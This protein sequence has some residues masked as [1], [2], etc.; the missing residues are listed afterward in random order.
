MFANIHSFSSIRKRDIA[1]LGVLLAGLLVYAPANVQ[2]LCDV[3]PQVTD[4]YRAA[5]GSTT[6]PFAAPGRSVELLVRSA[7][8]DHAS[9]SA[10]PD[11]ALDASSYDLSIIFTP[12]TVGAKHNL[13]VLRSSCSGIDANTCSDLGS[14]LPNG[15]TVT[16]LE[17]AEAPLRIREVDL[18]SGVIER[19]LCFDFPTAS[20]PGP[21]DENTLTGPAKLVVT[22]ATDPLP[23]GL[24]T[25]RCADSTDRLV[26]CVDELYEIDST[27][28]TDLDRLDP[29]FPTFTALPVENRFEDVCTADPEDPD[30]ICQAEG[31]VE[32][33][34]T[35]DLLGN[36]HVPFN[37]SAA[38]VRVG[39]EP[40]PLLVSGE[41]LSGA[42]D[43]DGSE[44]P[45]LSR[46][47]GESRALNGRP[48]PPI[49]E[50]SAEALGKVFGSVDAPAGV[51][52]L[53]RFSSTFTQCQGGANNGK[54]CTSGDQCAEGGGIC[55]PATCVGGTNAG[56]VCTDQSTCLEG[57]GFCGPPVYDVAHLISL[58]GAGSG[59]ALGQATIE[60]VVS[61]NFLVGGEATDRALV[62]EVDESVFGK[63]VNFDSDLADT[64]LV[65]RKR[66]T[67]EVFPIGQLGS[68]GLPADGRALTRI[69]VPPFSLPGAAVEDDVFA[70]LEGE[71]LEGELDANQNDVV[72]ESNLR[73][74]RL[75]ET[76][77]EPLFPPDEENQLAVEPELLVNGQ[78]VVVSNGRVF[79]RI[80]QGGNLPQE[81]IL[82]NVDSDGIPSDGAAQVTDI[83]G[84]SRFVVFTSAGKDLV[85]RDKNRVDD[86]F[87]R[88][89]IEPGMTTRVSV[90]NDPKGKRQGCENPKIIQANA[91]S[92]NGVISENGGVVAFESDADNLVKDDDNGVTDIFVR[93]LT[94][95]KTA[96][97]SVS[98][99]T[100]EE[101]NAAS[102][103]PAISDDG[104][105]IV[106]QSLATNLA[107]GV[108][109]GGE[110]V[111]VHDRGSETEPPTTTLA[112]VAGAEPANGASLNPDISP[113]GSCVAFESAA[114]DLVLD[115]LN[116]WQDVF[117]HDLS[118]GVTDIFSVDSNGLQTD[119]DSFA[120]SCAGACDRAAYESDASNLVGDDTNGETDVFVR[121]R[122][123]G[124][125]RRVS[126][127]ST[128]AECAS[129][130]ACTS[131]PS[132]NP[133][134][135]AG[136]RF[137]V[138]QSSSDDLVPNDANG[139][140]DI[141]VKDLNTGFIKRVS[142]SQGAGG[143]D[144]SGEPVISADG[145]FVAFTSSAT[146]LGPSLGRAESNVFLHGPLG[147]TLSGG[148]TLGVLDTRADPPALIQTGVAARS[149][150]VEDGA[151]GFVSEDSIRLLRYSC[152]GDEFAGG[153]SCATDADCEGGPCLPV[154]E[155]LGRPGVD[156]AVSDRFLCA[157]VSDT[158]GPPSTVACHGIGDPPGASLEDVF[159]PSGLPAPADS[160]GVCGSTAVFISPQSGERRLYTVDLNAHALDPT[161]AAAR[162]VPVQLA[163]EFVL[164][165]PVPADE[166]SGLPE[167]CLGAFR[168]SEGSL[169]LGSC[170][171]NGD[172]D[173]LDFGMHLLKVTAGD[174]PVASP[175]G[176]S[177]ITCQFSACDVR[178]PYTCGTTF[179]KYLMDENDEG[180][181]DA[182]DDGILG[183]V[184]QR[185]SDAA[186]V[187]LG[188]PFDPNSAENPVEDNATVVGLVRRCI[189]PSWQ[190]GNFCA[191]EDDCAAG[192]TCSPVT[193]V[194]LEPDA[195]QDGIPDVADN[196]P[197]IANPDQADGDGDG[198][199][200]A[201]DD[202]TCDD[203]IEQDA[204]WCDD[205]YANGTEDSDCAANCTPRVRID[206]SE[207]SI[208]P[209][210]GGVVP[211]TIY[212]S[213]LLNL[214]TSPV[215]GLPPQMIDVGSLRFRASEPGQPCPAGGAAPAHEGGHL[216]D[217]NGDGI[218]DL[219]THYT[220]AETGIDFGTVEG[221]L[222]GAFSV[223][224]GEFSVTTFEERDE[225]NVTGQ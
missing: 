41:M 50:L 198:I 170:D 119:A 61:L 107:L 102:S 177:A 4:R 125:T 106:F 81:T 209:T 141:F 97:I 49:F 206:V 220:V 147:L 68:D 19:R 126:V 10:S 86:V 113:D 208:N 192:E 219:G 12:T 53:F 65:A 175:C 150:V 91:A 80:S 161:S 89:S 76:E 32:F 23:C 78:A 173:C 135:S 37:Y 143:N 158:G 17:P 57:G 130:A 202:F 30:S 160:I 224:V 51:H 11:F 137:V 87:V 28:R 222:T 144:D 60:G 121:D 136:G 140:D 116:G 40:Y 5:L 205:G 8:C 214:D 159:L 193:T 151:A 67:G 35:T 182:N 134:L 201:C 197:Q 194:A 110:N 172:S 122:S 203:G 127:S 83:S 124:I 169:P 85:D 217:R 184:S 64:A 180:G 47:G 15:G 178:S 128:G 31:P 148:P 155:D 103:N 149:V 54:P 66:A 138:F 118:S 207:Q 27:C 145:N 111:Y 212:G 218:I 154:L 131:G 163:E 36:I 156:V 117:S 191:S 63:G 114:D 183:I 189:D 204:E 59:G 95:C 16:C 22:L 74:Y 90:A 7:L 62:T 34:F 33:R 99:T 96:R 29:S 221:C 129:P 167:T 56:A 171:L 225:V 216:T 88:D 108:D 92:G 213:S 196:C 20:V 42:F 211:V 210:Q 157:R 153:P 14:P 199:G 100:G 179:C 176:T 174:D 48:L 3:I 75:G 215:D 72:F 39:A 185:C 6:R 123:S 79:F 223:T 164:G 188:L 146:N 165:E 101:A 26:A 187:T 24:A 168:T 77:A 115:D 69:S 2:A 104:R 133:T 200:D 190:V 73:A 9:R 70:F 18:G 21:P 98:T 82:A 181:I 46:T 52:R 71:P 55:A 120:P 25:T 1:R 139:R 152:G 43:E 44:P 132:G 142:A 112:S 84:D 186:G 162:A 94:T 38:L 45:D 166:G 105:L 13:V 58:D 93:D 195:D 109:P